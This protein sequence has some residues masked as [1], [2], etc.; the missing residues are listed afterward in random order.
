MSWHSRLANVFRGTR[1]SNDIDREVAFHLAELED[2]LV[3]RGMSRDGARWQARRR[4]GNVGRQ[5]ERMRDA[6][7]L[8]WLDSLLADVRY[9]ARTLRASAGFTTVAVASLALGIGANTA[10]F[11]L[12]NAVMLR[13]LPVRDPQALVLVGMAGGDATSFTNPLWE[14]VRDHAGVFDGVL[15][16][17]SATFNLAESGEE[18][19]AD[20]LWV[21][22]SFFNVLGVRAALGRVLGPGDD[23]RGC[24]AT[25]VVSHAFWRA[26]LGGDPAVVGRSMSFNGQRFDI[27]GV[28]EPGFTGLEVGR[29]PSFY[30]PLC[31]AAVLDPSGSFLDHRSWWFLNV[32]G[33][34]PTG[35][36][37]TQANA[38]LAQVSPA[39]FAATLPAHFSV[40]NQR[41]YLGRS[42]DVRPSLNALSGLRQAYAAA[43]VVLM[44]IVGLVLLIACANVA[45][46]ML[47]RATVRQRELAVRI[48]L[49][50]G[51][52]RIVRQLF[53]EGLL[54]SSVGAA[55]GVA[56]AWWGSRL[57][58]A[59]L[60]TTRNPVSLELGPDGA[61]L[62][63]TVAVAVATAVL[64]GL[65]PAWRALRTDPQG[66]MKAHGRS[67]VESQSR[68][69]IGKVLVTLQVALSLV[70]VTGAALLLGSFRAMATVDAG[71]DPSRVL[72]VEANLRLPRAQLARG[73]EE[74]R[75]IVERLRAIRGVERASSAFNTPLGRST[76]NDL[77]VIPG[78][79]PSRRPED[80]EIYLNQVWDGYFATLGMR[81]LSGRDFE[82]RDV[83]GSPKVAII[84]QTAAERY[85]GAK[86][87]VGRMFRMALGDGTTPPITVIGVVSDAKYQTLREET[88]PTAFFAM[89][90]DT[91]F[92]ANVTFV[93]KGAGDV[94]DL[95]ASVAR[96]VMEVSPRATLR[97][98]P[99]E[100]QVSDTMTRERVLATLSVFFGGLAL[101]L[102][103]IGLYGTM[104]YT[105]ARRRS[106]IGIR[107]ALGAAESRV[108]GGVLREVALVL[109][110]GL[111]LGSVGVLGTTRLVE[112]FLF[113]VTPRDPAVLAG[114]AVLL[115]VVAFVAGWLPARRASRLDPMQTLREE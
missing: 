7:I 63:F 98:R 93:V 100:L 23:V 70:L 114:S 94:A 11:S 58:V 54:L 53:V 67:V 59:F 37:T 24:P 77:V 21:S 72:V 82:A 16:Y 57:L 17:G 109:G 112:R 89:A 43:L 34:L 104:S 84:N 102:A 71:F 113:G 13:D 47:A 18:R 79:P 28:V 22:G 14:Q 56:L 15:A 55:A 108:L 2:E 45:N 30:V 73:I 10:I 4:F 86:D 12:V 99:L 33:R 74:Q 91:S 68:F 25:A 80:R 65:A 62:G 9:A 111:L 60:S 106:E 87:P 26:E 85:F 115:S 81:L 35:T 44:A 8:A 20:G 32:I 88:L 107:L 76:W 36:T 1:L 75:R 95:R 110:I 105:V 101:L 66:A 27:A 64:F 31:A 39:L 48:A 78:A 38:R 92:G 83:P 42:L 3:A 97:L 61:V 6:N 103:M 96:A 46:L 29:A 69:G 41:D 49:G 50:A 19:P 51:R 52:G 5:Q 40:E 90:Q